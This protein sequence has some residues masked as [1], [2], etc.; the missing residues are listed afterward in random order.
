MLPGGIK[1]GIEFSSGTTFSA[2]FEQPVDEAAVR[3]S[4][5][6]SGTRT[7]ASRRLPTASF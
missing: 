1:K 5:R 6:G 7:P 4:W 2:K 3:L